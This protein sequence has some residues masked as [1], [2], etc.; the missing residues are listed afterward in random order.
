M[1]KN[2]V[3]TAAPSVDVPRLVRCSSLE[4]ENAS[5]PRGPSFE[6][7]INKRGGSVSASGAAI[8]SSRVVGIL[9]GP[10]G[11]VS[12]SLSVNP[13]S[14]VA[15]NAVVG[16]EAS[17]GVSGDTD[18][19]RG[20]WRAGLLHVS[21]NLGDDFGVGHT[22][23]LVLDISSTNVK[24]HARRADAENN[25]TPSTT[26]HEPTCSD[27]SYSTGG[28]CCNHEQVPDAQPAPCE[29]HQGISLSSDAHPARP[30]SLP[31]QL[32]NSS[33]AATA[34]L[35]G[36]S[37]LGSSK[38]P[39]CRYLAL[40]SYKG[41]SSLVFTLVAEDL[42][43]AEAMLS[44]IKDTAALDRG[45]Y[46]ENPDSHGFILPNVKEHAPLSAGARVD[47]GVEVETTE[48]HENRA[49][50]RGC[51]VSSCSISSFLLEGLR[52][53]DPAVRVM[54]W[55]AVFNAIMVVAFLIYKLTA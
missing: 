44:A 13:R 5:P 24:G 1:K 19:P 11:G 36:D 16:E 17:L 23:D 29:S 8:T 54:K 45:H 4:G 15:I 14:F 39:C 32:G 31:E 3:N 55:L 48:N 35:V 25:H 50:D 18:I 9:D 7:S 21:I 26:S 46:G 43:E 12:G 52:H 10:S 38:K 51:C 40:Y 41:K 2:D 22:I 42:A 28:G 30:Q 49:A 47:H 27:S 53:K 33:V 37:D 6:V 34:T 20:I